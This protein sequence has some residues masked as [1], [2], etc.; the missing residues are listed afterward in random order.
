MLLAPYGK[1]AVRDNLCGEDALNAL[2]ES[3]EHLFLELSVHQIAII[4]RA[5]LCHVAEHLERI[6]HRIVVIGDV[7][8][9][10]MWMRPEL[11]PPAIIVLSAEQ[12]HDAFL[13][14][15]AIL[16]VACSLV[17]TCQ[18]GELHVGG[19]VVGGG[20]VDSL[21]FF[22]QRVALGV[23]QRARHV[24]VLR[25]SACNALIEQYLLTDALCFCRLVES[26]VG[27]DES[28]GALCVTGHDSQQ[29]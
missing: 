21:L 14:G 18:K 4:G 8:L 19:S 15:V 25:P 12:I 10:T 16:P 26:W 28:V 3:L 7:Y 6:H 1:F 20:V 22:Q 13:E 23:R 17:E 11:R 2:I 5:L 29:C 24:D 27:F 9:I